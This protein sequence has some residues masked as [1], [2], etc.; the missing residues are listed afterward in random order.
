MSSKALPTRETAEPITNRVT[1]DNA[2]NDQ[3]EQAK[4]S[5]VSEQHTEVRVAID[6]KKEPSST[7]NPVQ[8]EKP[9]TSV[10]I[11]SSGTAQKEQQKDQ[12]AKTDSLSEEKETSSLPKLASTSYTK[13][14]VP[15]V[16]ASTTEQLVTQSPAPIDSNQA[17][18]SDEKK[19]TRPTSTSTI[20]D[21]KISAKGDESENIPM[22]P[23]IST[24]GPPPSSANQQEEQGEE[25]KGLPLSAPEPASQTPGSQTLV[26]SPAGGETLTALSTENPILKQAGPTAPQGHSSKDGEGSP[27]QSDITAVSGPDAQKPGSLKIITDLASSREE[28]E[29]DDIG[30][31]V[32]S[33]SNSSKTGRRKLVYSMS[34]SDKN[35]LKRRY[36]GILLVLFL[37]Y[38]VLA[39]LCCQFLSSQIRGDFDYRMLSFAFGTCFFCIM[40]GSV[41]SVQDEGNKERKASGYCAAA[42]AF[43]S[44]VSHF[45]IGFHGTP[46][47]ENFAGQRIETIR[48]VEEVT[49]V[50]II[51]LVLETM[52]WRGKMSVYSILFQVVA[53]TFWAAGV[54]CNMMVLGL[55]LAG[56]GCAFYAYIFIMWRSTLKEWLGNRRKGSLHRDHNIEKTWGIVN[57]YFI[58]A[59]ILIAIHVLGFL[60]LFSDLEQ[61]VLL[62]LLDLVAKLIYSGKGNAKQSEF[63][64]MT[65]EYVKLI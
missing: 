19:D 16:S 25:K 36:K 3:K 50:A 62:S 64:K 46:L 17:E 40:C 58:T 20:S 52:N 6:D 10:L 12:T 55:L 22:I 43:L 35:V 41:F 38:G 28:Q 7:L 13:D 32:L 4:D 59:D 49:E 65:K 14:P 27:V 61:N 11:A 37:I 47:L 26:S 29:I 24:D 21:S 63:L 15:G 45:V 44:F 53:T 9:S 54:L 42:L 33:M 1:A 31:T 57:T 30:H 5:S 39:F 51:I 23:S 56:I 60:K 18:A 48:W 2:T 34:Y 8:P